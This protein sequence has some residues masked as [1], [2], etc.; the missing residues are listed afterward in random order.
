MLHSAENV[1][2]TFGSRRAVL[3]ARFAS[4]GRHELWCR[5][6]AKF[7]RRDAA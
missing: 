6:A 2:K 4:S 7:R 3:I 5:V 1:S